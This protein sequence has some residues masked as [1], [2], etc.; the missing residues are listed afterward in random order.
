MHIVWGVPGPTH[1]SKDRYA[2]H[3]LNVHLGGGMSS[4]L[5]QEIREK[6]GLAYTVY[7]SI[8][9]FVD[10]GVFT[11]YAATSMHQVP[12]C[13][14]LIEETIVKVKK[15]LLTQEE[16]K[17][18]KDSLK[19]TVLL[20]SDSTESRMFSIARNEIF[21]DQHVGV[22]EICEQL[23]RV[24]PQDIRRVARKIL[25]QDR[26]SILFLGP[27]PRPQMISR[28]KPLKFL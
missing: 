2:A 3:L 27:K 15:D 17:S 1:S 14:K 16:M 21:L 5:F 11:I 19:G 8:S 23:D 10:S 7:S 12:L 22:E 28:L 25:R 9:P 13:L 18:V 4:V 26:R 20:S 6:N 24:T